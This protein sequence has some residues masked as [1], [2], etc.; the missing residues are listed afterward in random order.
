MHAVAG[1]IEGCAKG[2]CLDEALREHVMFAV[3]SN[4]LFVQCLW[5][6]DLC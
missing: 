5:L 1:F 6:V 2:I 4:L 3:F